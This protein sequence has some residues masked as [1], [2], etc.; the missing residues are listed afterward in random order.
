MATK[1]V[2]AGIYTQ[3]PG[4]YSKVDRSGLATMGALPTGIVAMVGEAAGGGAGGG[5]ALL[6]LN[7]PQAVLDAY[8]S[9]PLKEGAIIAF[10]PCLDDQVTG[11]SK[12]IACKVNPASQAAATP[13]E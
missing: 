10:D 9:G 5:T 6:T 12:V 1:L 3:V 13:G 7:N 2:F 4:A 8:R 11:A